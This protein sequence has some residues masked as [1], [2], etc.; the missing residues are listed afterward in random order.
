VDEA[1][2]GFMS[3]SF[4]VSFLVEALWETWFVEA[5]VLAVFMV[6]SLVWWVATAFVVS[7]LVCDFGL[8]G[9]LAG[10]G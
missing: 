2:V 1:L 6:F 4:V 9:F 5:W 3:V 10:T 8:T 7:D